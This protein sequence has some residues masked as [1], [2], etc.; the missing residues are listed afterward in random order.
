MNDAKNYRWL[1]NLLSAVRIPLAAAVYWAAISLQWQLAFWLLVVALMTDFFDGLA[2]KKLHAE[3]VLGSHI[4]RVA[5]FTLA[6]AGVLGLVVAT[7]IF[8]M[9]VVYAGLIAASFIG[10]IKFFTPPQSVIFRITSLFSLPLL[11]ASWIFNAWGFLSMSYGWSWW[12]PVVT[13]M[14]LLI[15]ASLKKHRLRSWF[16]WLAPNAGNRFGKGPKGPK[17]KND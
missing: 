9:A 7:E 11:F 17:L 2:A 5:D 16:G 8:S 6:L 12:Y 1:P 4:D 14:M 10:A 15:A 13:T 3:S